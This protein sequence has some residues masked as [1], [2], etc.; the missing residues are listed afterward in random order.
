[1][2]QRLPALGTSE[3]AVYHLVEA[4]RVTV[5]TC[6][7]YR[8]ELRALAEHGLV[9]RTDDGGWAPILVQGQPAPKTTP[10]P[11]DV[12]IDVALPPVRQPT[13][14]PSAPPVHGPPMNTLVARVPQEWLDVLDAMGPTRSEALRAVLGKALAARSGSRRAVG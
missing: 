9:Q 12:A 7:M 6:G 11:R 10:P 4:G 1:M 3:R 13:M 8:R 2:K 14:L 5:Y